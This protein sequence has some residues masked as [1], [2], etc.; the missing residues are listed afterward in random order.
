MLLFFP[1]GIFLIPEISYFMLI[2]GGGAW[3]QQMSSPVSVSLSEA[4]TDK[5]NDEQGSATYSKDIFNYWVF[6][7]ITLKRWK[8]TTLS[9]ISKNWP[10][11]L[12]FI[13]WFM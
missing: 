3:T 8:H 1:L 9:L 10:F 12:A 7:C 6:G 13:Q 2:S 5:Y 11:N 4:A